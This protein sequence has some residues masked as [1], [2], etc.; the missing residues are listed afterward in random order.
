MRADNPIHYVPQT[1]DNAWIAREVDRWRSRRDA[2]RAELGVRGRVLLTPSRLL[3]HKGIAQYVAALHRLRARG[4]NAC[5]TALV[6]GAGPE[7]PR[8]RAAAAELGGAVRWLGQVAYADLPRLRP[9]MLKPQVLRDCWGRINEDSA[10]PP[11]LDRVMQVPQS[12]CSVASWGA[13]STRRPAD[14]TRRWMRRSRKCWGP[15]LI[16]A[17][18]RCRGLR[19]ERCRGCAVARDPPCPVGAASGH[20]HARARAWAGPRRLRNHCGVR[21]GGPSAQ[22]VARVLLLERRSVGSRN[23]SR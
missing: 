21:H 3:A 1:V 2:V 6:A 10:G 19:A 4:K 23:V 7:E 5:F 8:L 11:V 15:G 20:V 17:A 14:S 13:S 9:P 12:S 18:R 16:R 22:A